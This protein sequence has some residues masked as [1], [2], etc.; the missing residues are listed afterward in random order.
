MFEL[1][2]LPTHLLALVPPGSETEHLLLAGGACTLAAYERE[3]LIISA[4]ESVIDDHFIG[5]LSRHRRW[6]DLDRFDRRK[7]AAAFAHCLSA[8][9]LRLERQSEK[10]CCGP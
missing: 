9:S 3:D 10:P 5:R 4:L 6:T 8:V 2:A 7:V 1:L